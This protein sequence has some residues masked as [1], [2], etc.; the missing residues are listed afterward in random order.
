MQ[1]VLGVA[2]IRYVAV[3][4]SSNN[5]RIRYQKYSQ[6]GQANTTHIY[7]I[8]LVIVIFLIWTAPCIQSLIEYHWGL[9]CNNQTTH[10]QSHTRTRLYIWCII[11]NISTYVHAQCPI[12]T[13]ATYNFV[14]VQSEIN[15]QLIWLNKIKLS[16]YIYVSTSLHYI[17]YIQ[18]SA[19]GYSTSSHRP[20][21]Y[22][23]RTINTVKWN[24][25]NRKCKWILLL[26]AWSSM[27]NFQLESNEN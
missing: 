24:M 7:F 18:F 26:L 11:Y 21:P 1:Y 19:C 4:G 2:S 14:F 12:Y 8:Y 15:T 17:K 9:L 5:N 10:T 27:Q 3:V 13:Y 6:W 23:W 22:V 20:Y 25:L 16:T